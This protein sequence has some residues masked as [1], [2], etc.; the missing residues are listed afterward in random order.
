MYKNQPQISSS[1]FPSFALYKICDSVKNIKELILPTLQ[2]KICNDKLSFILHDIIAIDI[3]YD[4][5]IAFVDFKMCELSV[6]MDHTGPANLV[7]TLSLSHRP[8]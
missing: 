6:K 2:K 7:L 8:S 4:D 5:D 1:C 3:E